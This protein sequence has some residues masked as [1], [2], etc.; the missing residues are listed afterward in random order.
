MKSRRIALF[1]PS[2]MVEISVSTTKPRNPEYE[3]RAEVNRVKLVHVAEVSVTETITAEATKVIRREKSTGGW[4]IGLM[5]RGIGE[6]S[7]SAHRPGIADLRTPTERRSI[8]GW[9]MLLR[10]G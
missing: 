6:G 1:T 5:E 3:T 9:S 2:I 7:E 8:Q 10:G 4:G